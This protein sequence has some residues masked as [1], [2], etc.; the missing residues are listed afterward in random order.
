MVKLRWYQVNYRELHPSDYSQVLDDLIEISDPLLNKQI[1][2]YMTKWFT[3]KAKQ[4]SRRFLERELEDVDA[5]YEEFYHIAMIAA[6][7]LRARIN[8]PV[9]TDSA[10]FRNMTHSYGDAATF[11]CKLQH[12]P[13]WKDRCLDALMDSMDLYVENGTPKDKEDVNNLVDNA[14]WHSANFLRD[15]GNYPKWRG[16][17]FEFEL[18]KA[19]Y[20]KRNKLTE[21]QQKALSNAH[22]LALS[23]FHFTG[24]FQWFRNFLI[25]GEEIADT[26]LREGD[27][28]TASRHYAKIKIGYQILMEKRGIDTTKDI[29]EMR[30]RAQELGK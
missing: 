18:K 27:L 21:T 19:E 13:K 1:S 25:V 3:K 6:N 2:P 14:F 28:A 11:A 17:E 20:A 30:Q 5:F 12:L 29:A 4:L 8:P 10:Y 26:H 7:R 24:E 16:R 22:L 23:I 9:E 15:D